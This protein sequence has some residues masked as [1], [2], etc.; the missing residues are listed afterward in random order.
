MGY[1]PDFSA[2]GL[3]GIQAGDGYVQCFRIEA[4]EAFID[5]QRFNSG[6]IWKI[7][8]LTL[9]PMPGRG[10]LKANNGRD[11]QHTQTP[12]NN[13]NLA[14]ELQQRLLWLKPLLQRSCL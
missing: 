11:N 12:S 10:D 2:Q 5:K 8:M 14:G 4:T 13:F 6:S 9:R 3:Q 1:Y 7:A